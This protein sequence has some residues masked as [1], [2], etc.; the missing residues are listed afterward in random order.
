MVLGSD[1]VGIPSRGVPSVPSMGVPQKDIF[2]ARAMNF[3]C[4]G[5]PSGLRIP[6]MVNVYMANW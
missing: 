2:V 5:I 3:P 4:V 6:E 1:L